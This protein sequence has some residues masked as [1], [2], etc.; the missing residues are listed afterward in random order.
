MKSRMTNGHFLMENHY[1]KNNVLAALS[2]PDFYAGLLTH[3]EKDD[4]SCKALADVYGLVAKKLFGKTLEDTFLTDVYY[5]VLN[6]SFPEAVTVEVKSNEKIYDFYLALL[7]VFNGYQ[8]SS[9]DGSFMSIYPMDML[10]KHEVLALDES[11]EYMAFEEGFKKQNIY[12]MMK[13]NYEVTGHSTIEHI[14]G[15]HH[16]AMTIARQLKN[17]GTTIDLGR[18]S[19]AAAGHD[20]GKFG[21]RPEE[22]NK[23]AYYHYYYTDEWFTKLDIKYIKNVAVYHSTWDLELESLSIESLVL[24]YSDFCVKRSQDKKGIFKM[25]FLSVEESYKVILNKLDNMN[26]LKKKRYEKV[27]QKLKNF[28][29]YLEHIGINITI[30][31]Y[32][33]SPLKVEEIKARTNEKYSALQEGNIVVDHMKFMAIEKSVDLMYRLRDINSLNGIIQEAKNEKDMQ[34]FRRYLFIFEEYST[35]LTPEQKM[36]TLNFLL[37]YTIHSEEDIRKEASYLIGKLLAEYDENYTKELPIRAQNNFTVETKF[38]KIKSLIHQFILHEVRMTPIKRIRQVSSFYYILEALFDREKELFT[39]VLTDMLLACYGQKTDV[40]GEMF[41]LEIL[42]ILPLHDLLSD[43]KK[44]LMD[45]VIGLL[46]ASEEVRILAYSQL[47]FLLNHFSEAEKQHY[48]DF[49]GLN[50][51]E[52]SSDIER[53]LLSSSLKLGDMTETIELSKSDMFLG[54]LKTATPKVVKM[55]QIEMLYKY[56]IQKNREERFYTAMHFCNILKVSAHESVR[57]KA[58][59][60]LVLLFEMLSSEQKNDIVIEL[61]RALEI[62]GYGFTRYIPKFLGQLIPTLNTKEYHEILNDINYKISNAGIN[63]RVLLLDT[64]GTMIGK[65]LKMGRGECLDGLL[66]SIFKGFYS[67]SK[68]TAQMAFNVISKDIIGNDH[69]EL[70]SRFAIFKKLYK[71]LHVFLMDNHNYVSLDLFNYTVGLHYIYHFITEYNFYKG[72]MVFE[73]TMKVAYYS[74]TFDPF[75]LGQKSAAMDAKKLG[76]EVFI[77]ISEFQWKRRTQPSLMRKEIIEM[78][79]SDQMSIYTFPQS[80]PINLR[81]KE[82]LEKLKTLFDEKPVYLIIGEEALLHD[83]VYENADNAIYSFPHIIYS[84]SSMAHTDAFKELIQERIGFMKSDVV[85]RSLEYKYEMIDVNQIRR[86]IDNNWDAYDVIDDLATHFI[87]SHNLYKNEPQFKSVVTLNDLNIEI[88]PL[89]SVDNLE[90]LCEKFDVDF[91]RV[92]YLQDGNDSEKCP[93]LK[94]EMLLIKDGVTDQVVAFSIFAKASPEHLFDEIKSLDILKDISGKAYKKIL[95]LDEIVMKPYGKVHALDQIILTETLMSLIPS[96]FEYAVVNCHDMNQFSNDIRGVLIRSGF[97]KYQCTYNNKMLYAVDMTEPIVINLDGTT[98]MKTDYRQ[99]EDIRD[100]IKLVR[101]NLQQAVVSLY[102]GSLVLSF[103]RSM[104]YSHLIRQITQ[105]NKVSIHHTGENGPYMCVPYGDI[106][107]RW[108]LPNTVTKSFHTER[109]YNKYVEYYD[110]KAYPGYLSIEE[111]ARVLK[112]FNRPMILVD[113]LVDKGNRLNSIDQYLK[114]NGIDI[115]QVIV[116]IMSDRG[117]ALFER[118][119]MTLSAA[120]HIPNIKI[121]FN[122]ADVYP[123]IGGDSLLRESS[124]SSTLLSSVN[125]MLPF[126]Y[127]KYI[128]DVSKMDLYNL[129]MICLENAAS[130]LNEV[131]KVYMSLNNR[132]LS[133]EN[134]KE[135]MITPRVPDVGEHMYYDNNF[136]PTDFLKNEIERLTKMKDAFNETI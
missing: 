115:D 85:I 67:G 102:P 109:Y 118:K 103:D 71:K 19:G 123:F 61:I 23:I 64:V 22:K 62:E 32:T 53:Y 38:N 68:L 125:M 37:D 74:G 70:H 126:V 106:F 88:K 119:G 46:H 40:Y 6:K 59:S 81:H 51:K 57:N 100:K 111:Q 11:S 128:S 117:K 92:K 84:R 127:P 75:S 101:T 43:Q 1:E 121:W 18:V 15:V 86:N 41:L 110:V 2:T 30:E 3:V 69:L 135:V 33:A 112:A 91:S 107:K 130:I 36:M 96:G 7:T 131:E 136:K 98:R 58:G 49:Y 44:S 34:M 31:N 5:F 45:F 76:F 82:D 26:D 47:S 10:S 80:L 55:A 114:S 48:I 90:M 16:L 129:S 66:G 77:G 50:H 113:D 79:I 52:Y 72:E 13:L 116:G 27:Y 65:W 4:Y 35:Y 94:R 28:S 39:F 73:N 87:K 9:Q 24:I 8:T 17:L 108:L 63:V 97:I 133:I 83:V 104:M 89:K 20:I 25:K 124:N 134:L 56:S 122:E 42:S 132:C 99:H 95:I 21:C 54:N 78:S 105:R 60:Y 120:Y 29:E 93:V 12:E 14:L